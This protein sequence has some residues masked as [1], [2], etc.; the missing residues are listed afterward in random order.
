MHSLQIDIEPRNAP[1]QIGPAVWVFARL[2]CRGV[3]VLFL[4]VCV[5]FLPPL[6]G[7]RVP[8]RVVK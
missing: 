2:V 4:F 8:V 6:V 1:L 5:F 7:S 3:D